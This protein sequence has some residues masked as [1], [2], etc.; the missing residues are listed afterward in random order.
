MSHFP[1]LSSRGMLACTS[2][3]AMDRAARSSCDKHRFIFDHPSPTVIWTLRRVLTSVWPPRSGKQLLMNSGMD[4]KWSGV[5]ISS[6]CGDLIVSAVHVGW[7]AT[8]VATS[9]PLQAVAGVPHMGVEGAC[10]SEA[11]VRTST[12][13]LAAARRHGRAPRTHSPTVG[14]A[15]TLG[16]CSPVLLAGCAV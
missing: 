12:H 11:R 7:E 10:D 3:G 2:H 14:G 15:S 16:P 5:R 8:L 6:R 1:S 4:L 13:A 9:L